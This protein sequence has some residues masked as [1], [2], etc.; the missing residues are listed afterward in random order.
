M[1]ITK[2]YILLILLGVIILGFPFRR[3]L[4]RPGAAII[5]RI[6]GLKTINDRVE[7]YGDIARERLAD[8]FNQ[9][10]ISYPP[11]KIILAGLKQEK[12]L[13]IWAASDEKSFKLLKTYPILAASG[14]LGPKMR[15]GDG[16]VPEGLYKIESLNPNS[17]FHLALRVNYPNEFDMEKGALEK[18]SKLGG[19]IM[20]HGRSSSIGCLAMGNEAI[21]EIFVLAAETGIENISIILSPIDFRVREL[22]DNIHDQPMWTEELY[23]SIKAELKK[24]TQ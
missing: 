18:R 8:D 13:E 20:I 16:Q 23:D 12:K 6:Y 4:I 9:A 7:Q 5:Q 24:L 17:M 2:K 21:E 1:N 15:E 10:G 11:K 3:K 22:P 19:D 14:T